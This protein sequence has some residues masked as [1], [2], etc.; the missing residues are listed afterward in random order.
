MSVHVHVRVKGKCLAFALPPIPFP[1]KSSAFG[2]ERTGPSQMRGLENS[3]ELI[4]KSE[5]RQ[6]AACKGMNP[7]DFYLRQQA[8]KSVPINEKELKKL[9]RA[10]DVCLSCDFTEECLAESTVEDRSWGVWGGKL[11]VPMGK[12]QVVRKPGGPKVI[13]RSPRFSETATLEER[14]EKYLS[15]G[16]CNGRYTHVLTSP[17]DVI[18]RKNGGRAPAIY[19]RG[20]DRQHSADKKK[21]KREEEKRAKMAA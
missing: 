20:C 6:S 3:C 1:F 7:E 11:P 12:G 15:R 2:A 18:I 10:I 4:L 8:K 17:D 5:W 9:N 13:V 16:E 19:C 21:R 14:I